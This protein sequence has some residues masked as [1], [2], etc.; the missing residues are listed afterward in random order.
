M[1]LSQFKKLLTNE[2]YLNFEAY[3]KAEIQRCKDK[4]SESITLWL[5]KI[6]VEN[7]NRAKFWA[8]LIQVPH[9]K[10]QASKMSENK[11]KL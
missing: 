1:E 9:S 6:D 2:D 3:I 4:A 10:L 5:D 11:S 7:A 8:E